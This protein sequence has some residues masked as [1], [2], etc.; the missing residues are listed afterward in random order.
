M[1]DVKEKNGKCWLYSDKVKDHFLHPRNIFK[2]DQEEKEYQKNADGHGIVGSPAC[3]PPNSLVH[4]DEGLISIKQMIT[5]RKVLSHTGEFKKVN[6]VKERKFSDKLI[7]LK[8]KLGSISLTPNHLVYSIRKPK[9]YK[10]NYTRNRKNLAP[11]WN[12]AKNLKKNDFIIYP[13]LN[14]VYD[15]NY[16]YFNVLKKKYDFNSRELPKKIELT[17]ELLRLF[18]YYLSEGSTRK[19]KRRSNEVS[20]TFNINEKDYA[21]DTIYL[22]KKYFKLNGKVIERKDLNRI[23][24]VVYSVHLS[25]LFKEYFGC[26]A[27]DKKIPSFLMFLPTEKQNGLLCGLWRGDG[28]VNTTRRFPRAGYA[29]ISRELINQIKVLLLRQG[30]IH[31]IYR[32]KERVSRWAKHKQAYRIH[33]GD[34]DSVNKIMNIVYSK[35]TN[36]ISKQKTSWFDQDFFYTPLR[37]VEKVDYFGPVYNLEV[38]ENHNYTTEAFCV[39]NC[40][41]VMEMFIKV[42]DNKIT[43]CR[44]KTFGCASALASTS[45]LSEMVIGKTLKE[46]KKITPQDIVKALGGLP[47]RKIHCSV[48]GDQALRKAIEDYE[49]KKREDTSRFR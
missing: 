42:K 44:W 14:G 41:D 37:K 32:E 24:I 49:T 17:T 1:A 46:A 6:E 31:S 47:A 8:T 38:A 7:L 19:N 3:L 10:Y 34:L 45:I 15:R 35:N 39:H 26:G 16:L 28:Y 20:F 27:K 43:E 30:I 18:G 9:S 12:Y 33:V 21:D 40:G 23:D 4:S 29:S 25:N 36:F 13:K 48:L 5:K 11:E 22:L 2:N